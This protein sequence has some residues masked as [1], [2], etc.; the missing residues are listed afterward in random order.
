MRGQR[1]PRAQTDDREV[2]PQEE[3]PDPV[4]EPSGST[5]WAQAVCTQG[6][7]QQSVMSPQLQGPVRTEACRCA[8]SQVGQ[9][10]LSSAQQL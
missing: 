7:G 9:G 3:G 4:S 6:R 1:R 10:V 5:A 2:A 8:E